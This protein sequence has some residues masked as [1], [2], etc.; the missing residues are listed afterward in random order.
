MPTACSTKRPGKYDG[1]SSVYRIKMSSAYVVDPD[2]PMEIP[3]LVGD[4]PR[5]QAFLAIKANTIKGI[6]TRVP[7]PVPPGTSEAAVPSME[8][9][10]ADLPSKDFFLKT[11]TRP[12]YEAKTPTAS[13][14]GRAAAGARR[15][16]RR[17]SSSRK[18]RSNRYAMTCP[19]PVASAQNE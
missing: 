18:S 11:L 1:I 17:R 10:V 13:R 4:E 15:L 14:P 2:K 9:D 6:E 3:K 12:H 19:P 16:C 8:Y 7:Q 5:M